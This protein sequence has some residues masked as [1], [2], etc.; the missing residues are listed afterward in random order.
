MPADA[1]NDENEVKTLRREMHVAIEGV[2]DHLRI[3]AEASAG[4]DETII[5]R[6]EDLNKV[7][8][9][10]HETFRQ[11]LANDA[12]RITTLEQER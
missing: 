1:R 2:H 12:A 10:E 4:R 7:N 9:D 8:R 6:L 5:R 3:V 11:V